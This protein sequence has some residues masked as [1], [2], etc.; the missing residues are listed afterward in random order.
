[1]S[2][3][4]GETTAARILG[5]IRHRYLG[6][7]PTRR[8][9]VFGIG[10]SK[11]ATTSLSDALD[12]LGRRAAHMP[13]LT[14]IDA[15]GGIGLTWPWWVSKYDAA[16]DLS[17]AALYRELHAAFPN[18]RFVYTVRDVDRWL[19]SCRRHFTVELARR[20]VRQRNFWVLELTEA[21]YGSIV[22]DEAKF[23]AAFERHDAGVREFFAGPGRDRPPLEI[24]LTRTPAWEPLCTFLGAPV[25][26]APFPFSNRGRQE[27]GA[28]A[29]AA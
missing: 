4:A 2:D 17:V 10:L 3:P 23:R 13:P 28:D 25:P 22:Y 9:Y 1:M 6:Q 18:A 15:Q 26:D 19:N 16:T 21:F 11:T 24:D 27:R 7:V 5:A 12:M 14:R 8:P 29:G 20:R